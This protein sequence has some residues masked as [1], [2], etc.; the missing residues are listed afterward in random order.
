MLP[1]ASRVYA[2][3]LG[4]QRRQRA[5]GFASLPEHTVVGLPA[6]SPTMTHGNLAQWHKKVG[7]QSLS[8]RASEPCA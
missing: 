3:A 6:L 4:L 7:G 2:H 1:A 8:S 5:R